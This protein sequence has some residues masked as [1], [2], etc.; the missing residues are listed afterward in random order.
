VTTNLAKWILTADDKTKDAFASV[1]GNIKKTEDDIVGFAQSAAAALGV[2]FGMKEVIGAIVRLDSLKASLITVTGSADSAKDKFEELKKFAEETPFAMDEMVGGY[3]KLTARGINP[4]TDALRAFGNVASASGKSFD[5][6]VEA[7]ADAATY[8]FTRLEEFGINVVQ[9]A[10]SV[11][12]E[13]RG[14]KTK[15]GKNAQEITKYLTDL[16][17]NQYA[18]AM[19]LQTETLGGAF[20][21][22]RDKGLS[23][24]EALGEAGLTS[25]L[26]YA[27]KFM[28]ELGERVLTTKRLLGDL[29][30][31]KHST[32]LSN[33]TKVLT[34]DIINLTGEL[35]DLKK[36]APDWYM[37]AETRAPRARASEV[38]ELIKNKRD[39]LDKV[40]A[41]L[42]DIQGRYEAAQP[43]GAFVGPP[44]PPPP[45]PPK[46]NKALEKFIEDLKTDKTVVK[47]FND[48]ITVL[49][50]EFN[51]GNLSAERYADEVNRQDRR[52]RFQRPHYGT[53]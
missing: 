41:K 50:K 4:T 15:I 31:E 37:G 49:N 5:Q 21:A 32:A 43:K 13:F 29:F 27:S 47:D 48:R 6:M 53:Q 44:A 28:V 34:T 30:E 18:G 19:T 7:I 36:Q 42:A 14:V 8:Q 22:L 51:A 25:A 40:N 20:N 3:I 46:S 11:E 2:A 12:L 39:E 52:K 16:G 23:L 9:Q 35:A 17:N 33:R 24:A 26:I 45:P 38:E 10:D 1:S